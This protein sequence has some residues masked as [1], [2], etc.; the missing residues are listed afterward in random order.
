M[1]SQ[2]V[3]FNLDSL[4]YFLYYEP[5]YDPLDAKMVQIKIILL[6]IINNIK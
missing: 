3:R 2:A 5:W 4:V 6:V 1:N